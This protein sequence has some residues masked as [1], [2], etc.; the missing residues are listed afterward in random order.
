VPGGYATLYTIAKKRF[1]N[2][3][4]PYK[5]LFLNVDPNQ[6]GTE[7]QKAIVPIIRDQ[8]IYGY[9]G[10]NRRTLLSEA[11]GK[12]QSTYP[13]GSVDSLTD[14]Y[15]KI[16]VH[17]YD[18]HNFGPDLRNQPWDYFMFDPKETQAYDVSPWRYRTVTYPEG[19]EKWQAADFD[20]AK[21]GWKTGL[22]PFGQFDGKLVTDAAPCPSHDCGC[23]APMRTLWDKEVLLVHKTFKVPPLQPGHIYRIRTGQGQHVGSGD[24]YRI[25]IN[26]KLLIE[27]KTGN[28]KRT[29]GKPRGGFITSQFAEDFAKGEIAV[30]ATS[31]L[32]FGSKAI[33]QTPPVPQGIFSVWLEEMKLPPLDDEAISK[34]ATVIPMLTSAWQA[35]Q[36]PD[37]T[38]VQGEEDLFVYDGKFVANPKVLGSWTTVAQVDA[39]DK[40]T[41][42]QA[43]PEQAAPKKAASK[44]PAPKKPAK[45]VRFNITQMTFKDSGKTGDGLW[46]WSGDTLMDLD[47]YQALKMTVKTIGDSDYLFI[48]AGGFSEKNPVGWKTPLYV[49]KR[50][51]N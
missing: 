30:A 18:W 42:E 7:L 49:M 34:S 39:I 11:E 19:M 37:T 25:Y 32:R 20:P 13:Q 40:F 44:K 22:P 9:I 3:P 6:L 31:F 26:G 17:D 33:V 16:G 2:D 4:L 29:G 1:P 48:E 43:A 35:K 28:G 21:A 50:Q 36:D 27:T 41:P 23:K 12:A 45:S 38:E 46:I 5:E 47:R 14:L 15:R 8:L 10:K 24:G 51:A